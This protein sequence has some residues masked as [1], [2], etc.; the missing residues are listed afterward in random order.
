M[1]LIW[2][3]RTRAKVLAR[4]L[5]V[6]HACAKPAAQTVYQRVR[7]FTLF[8]IPVIPFSRKH[9]MQCSLCGMVSEITKEDA[10]R[11]VEA[12][13]QPAPAPELEPASAE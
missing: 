11:L 5:L 6:C 10:A 4:L 3:F 2:G 8:L 13:A 1:F 12:A 9:L 7:W